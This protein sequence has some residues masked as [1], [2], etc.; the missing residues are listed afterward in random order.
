MKPSLARRALIAFQQG[1]P[2][3]AEALLREEAG[4]GKEVSSPR[5]SPDPELREKAAIT[6]LWAV[7]DSEHGER[8]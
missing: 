5:H 7:L 8:H 1:H 3:Y 4:L 2:E 6:R